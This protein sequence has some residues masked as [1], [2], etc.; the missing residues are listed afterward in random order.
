MH[1]IFAAFQ[2]FDLPNGIATAQSIPF[3]SKRN[4]AAPFNVSPM[5]LQIVA[6]PPK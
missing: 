6:T 2:I 5:R 3:V 4:D 1:F